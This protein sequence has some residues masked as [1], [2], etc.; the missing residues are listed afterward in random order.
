MR[1]WLG[2]GTRGKPHE[3]VGVH[4]YEYE[5]LDVRKVITVIEGSLAK[6]FPRAEI[7]ETPAVKK[8]LGK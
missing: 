2:K 4:V 6:N 7:V 1:I 5:N 8:R 3:S